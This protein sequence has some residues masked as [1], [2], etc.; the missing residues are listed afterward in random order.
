M[1]KACGKACVV[2]LCRAARLC[3]SAAHGGQILAPLELVQQLVKSWAGTDLELQAHHKPAK[4]AKPHAEKGDFALPSIPLLPHHPP[5]GIA[6]S[7][8]RLAAKPHAEQ[9]SSSTVTGGPFQ[10]AKHV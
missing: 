8:P 10:V 6:K 2:V 5:F 3:H 7:L 9:G 1:L 4:A